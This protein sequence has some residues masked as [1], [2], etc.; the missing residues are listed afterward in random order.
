MK[1]IYELIYS[2][3]FVSL[4]DTS[5]R[6]DRARAKLKISGGIDGLCYNPKGFASSKFKLSPKLYMFHNGSNKIE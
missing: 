1:L 5:V 6:L 4:F 3:L 2:V